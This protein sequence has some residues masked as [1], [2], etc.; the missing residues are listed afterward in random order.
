VNVLVYAG[1]AL[2]AGLGA[3]LRYLATLRIPNW[4]G[5]LAV[6]ALGSVVLGALLAAGPSQRVSWI[7]GTAFCG[8]FTTFS[9]FA[10][11]ASD[12]SWERRSI[13]VVTTLVVCLG[14]AT[15]GNALG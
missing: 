11:D 3:A 10:L 7:V 8:S 1:F 15:I 6:N 12:G 14:A 5:T 4:L 9:T 13:V 2:A